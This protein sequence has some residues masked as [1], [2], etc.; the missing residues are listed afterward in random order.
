[1]VSKF[2]TKILKEEGLIPIHSFSGFHY[3]TTEHDFRWGS[4]LLWC[5]ISTTFHILVNLEEDPD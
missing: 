1:M 3:I 5:W 2:L 4:L